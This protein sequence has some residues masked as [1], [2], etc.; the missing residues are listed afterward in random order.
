MKLNEVSP[1]PEKVDV[2]F[3]QALDQFA[4]KHG[5]EVFFGGQAAVIDRGKYAWRIWYK[6]PGYEAFLD[7]LKAHKSPHLPKVYGEVRT[8]NTNFK[9]PKS[10]QPL[11]YLRIEKLAEMEPNLLSDA[12]NVIGLS[13]RTEWPATVEELAEL[14]LSMKMPRDA[15]AEPEDIQKVILSNKKFFEVVLDLLHAGADDINSGNVMMRGNVPVI[16]DP[17]KDAK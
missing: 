11:K 7:Y 15:D 17:I 16:T 8:A 5:G 9:G 1:F 10:G 6:D 3:R 2:T 13:F 12:L 4:E 14:T